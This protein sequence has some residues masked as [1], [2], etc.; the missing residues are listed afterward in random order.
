MKTYNNET[1]ITCTNTHWN[2]HTRS[3]KLYTN[4]STN[5]LYN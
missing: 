3:I 2:T 5:I 4:I 1:Y